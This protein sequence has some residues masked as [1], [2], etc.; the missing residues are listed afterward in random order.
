MKNRAAIA[1]AF[2]GLLA[3][4]AAPPT[5]PAPPPVSQPV[6]STGLSGPFKTFAFAEAEY[7]VAHYTRT[8]NFRL[9]DNGGFAL[10]YSSGSYTGTY[11]SEGAS[12]V[13]RWDGGSSGGVWGATGTLSGDKLTVRYN[14]IM[15]LSDFEDATYL[16]VR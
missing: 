11:T 13:F 9:Y 15:A 16:R 3:G 4:C 12:L 6:I 5:A 2:L 10:D 8:S 1:I 14:M 7:A